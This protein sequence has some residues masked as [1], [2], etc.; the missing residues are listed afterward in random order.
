[1]TI[2]AEVVAADERENGRRALLNYGH[3]LAHALESASEHRFRH[4][5]AVAVGLIYAAELARLM[6][7]IDDA[8]VQEHRRVVARYDLPDTVPVD[9]DPHDLVLLMGRDK[10]G[11]GGDLTFVLGSARGLEVV[12]GVDPAMALAALESVR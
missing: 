1:M 2:K 4:G 8:A 9:L 12:D 6:G 11:S 5:E 10:K 7:R 3:T